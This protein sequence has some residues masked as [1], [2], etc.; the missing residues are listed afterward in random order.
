ML[1]LLLSCVRC[2]GKGTELWDLLLCLVAMLRKQWC[3][4]HKMFLFTVTFSSLINSWE[5]KPH[6]VAW[7]TG[8]EQHAQL[9]YSDFLWHGNVYRNMWRVSSGTSYNISLL[10]NWILFILSL[11]KQ[12][13]KKTFLSEKFKKMTTGCGK[14]DLILLLS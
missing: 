11:N 12:W 3:V 7:S 4:V 13:Q 5:G 9:A 10:I 8:I 2:Y 6:S 14:R 1:P